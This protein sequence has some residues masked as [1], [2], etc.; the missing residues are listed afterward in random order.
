MSPTVSDG[1]A[2]C[3]IQTQPGRECPEPAHVVLFAT[4]DGPVGGRRYRVGGRILACLTHGG[5]L[6]DAL[7]Q[8]HSQWPSW[9]GDDPWITLPAPR[10][11]YH[12]SSQ[13]RPRSP[14]PWPTRR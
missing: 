9:L 12:A 14:R 7:H 3:A 8:D 5:Q 4:V 11:P 10:M 6:Y 2:L 1:P 13:D